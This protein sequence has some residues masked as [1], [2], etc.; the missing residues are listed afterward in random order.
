MSFYSYLK[1][2]NVSCRTIE[3]PKEAKIGC[4]ISVEFPPSEISRARAIVRYKQFKSFYCFL[5]VEKN[6]FKITTTKI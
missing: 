6:G 5:M 2:Y 1:N 4:G 3:T